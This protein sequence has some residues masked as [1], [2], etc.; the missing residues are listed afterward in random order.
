MII[1]WEPIYLE[2]GY[3]VELNFFRQWMVV[4]GIFG[5]VGFCWDPIFLESVYLIGLYL[6]G[7]WLFGGTQY[8]P[9]LGF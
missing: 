7:N 1:C 6:F 9:H 5:K 8:G 2:S 3:F 4:F